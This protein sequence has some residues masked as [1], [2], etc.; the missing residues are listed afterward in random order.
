MRRGH[1]EAALYYTIPYPT[2]TGIITSVFQYPH[3]PMAI[4]QV[5]GEY[6]MLWH[7]AKAGAFDLQHILMETLTS[8][9]RAGMLIYNLRRVNDP[10]T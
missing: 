7:G 6:A 2:T 10:L 1:N 8:M 4:Y 5:S 9:R 3:Y